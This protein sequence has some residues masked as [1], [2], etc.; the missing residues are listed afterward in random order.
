MSSLRLRLVLF[1]AGI[2]A[3]GLAACGVA[4]HLVVRRE[5]VAQ[6]D[7]VLIAQAHTIASLIEFDARNRSFDFMGRDVLTAEGT[8]LRAE[9]RSPDGTVIVRTAGSVPSDTDAPDAA[10]DPGAEPHTWSWQE[11][12]GGEH[13]RAVACRTRCTQDDD[14]NAHVAAPEITVRLARSSTALDARLQRIALLLTALTVGVSVVVGLALGF[15]IGRA[16]RPLRALT[17]RLAQWTGSKP[18]ERLPVPEYPREVV[19]VI[20]TLN[21]LFARI[22]ASLLRERAVGAAIAHEAR[23]PL[24]GLRTVLEVALSRQRSAAEA[25]TALGECLEMVAHLQQ[26]VDAILLLTRLE[27]GHVPLRPLPLD[28]AQVLRVAW[29]PFAACAASRGLAAGWQ[30]ADEATLTTDP[31]LLAIVVRNLFSNAADHSD[32][33]SSVT[34]TLSTRSDGVQLSVANPCAALPEHAG[35]L[36]FERFWRGDRARTLDEQ[37]CGLGLCLALE[38][39][40][41]LGGTLSATQ[42]AGVFTVTIALPG[43]PPQPAISRHA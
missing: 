17:D 29:E 10:N 18:G 36:V 39:A 43:E 16:L 21:D 32:A 26:L 42:H 6:F 15:G 7:E 41:A 13:W 23:T 24:A 28:L 25:R 30:L 9:A 34:I 35:T 3:L 33:G 20:A 14:G 38:A 11:E 1:S 31:E 37:H 12:N 27:Q 5:L 2:T 8:A 19:P 4:I 40:R 22:E